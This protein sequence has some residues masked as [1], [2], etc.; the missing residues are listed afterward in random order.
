MSH[1]RA[2]IGCKI[3]FM[4][5]FCIQG[6]HGYREL[7]VAAIGAEGAVGSSYRSRA[8]M[9]GKRQHQVLHTENVARGGKLSVSK[10]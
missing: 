7:W 1:D 5:H 2:S 3:T 6:C 10:M 9:S 4:K 8:S